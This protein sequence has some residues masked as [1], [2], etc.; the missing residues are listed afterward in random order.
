MKLHRIKLNAIEHRPLLKGLD[1][2]FTDDNDLSNV[3]PNC[4]IGI[5]GSGK[6]QLLETIA[7]IIF[8]FRPNI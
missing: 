5:N 8:L 6:S 4:F 3:D 7:D 1:L 2:S